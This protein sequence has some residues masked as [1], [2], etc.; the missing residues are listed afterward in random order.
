MIDFERNNNAT[1]N[2]FYVP[3]W[4]FLLQTICT[5]IF[6]VQNIISILNYFF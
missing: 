1:K 2:G 6:C 5:I 4:F 3:T